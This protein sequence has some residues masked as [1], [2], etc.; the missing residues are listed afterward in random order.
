VGFC[1]RLCWCPLVGWL[2]W[3]LS[4]WLSAVVVRLV[5]V[6]A[7]L[8]VIVAT[9][10]GCWGQEVTPLSILVT[11]LAICWGQLGDSSRDFGC[12]SRALGG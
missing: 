7:A 5:V 4:L 3:L 2:L 12:Y 9:L 10:S 6:V 11:S 8:A 1:P